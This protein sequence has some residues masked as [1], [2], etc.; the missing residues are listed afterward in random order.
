MYIRRDPTYQFYCIHT[1]QR[2]AKRGGGR[3]ALHEKNLMTARAS[4]LLK[5][6]AF[7]T[8]F[9]ACFLPGRAKDLSAPRY[10]YS[11]PT[12]GKFDLHLTF[13]KVSRVV[14]VPLHSNCVKCQLIYSVLYFVAYTEPNLCTCHLICLCE[15]DNT[16]S[17][18]YP[19]VIIIN[20]VHFVGGK[21]IYFRRRFGRN[22][23]REN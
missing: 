8:C 21:G 9:R 7:L 3:L 1:R 19:E 6:H 23:R 11:V 18:S 16:I 13:R 20:Y 12:C 15:L 2:S 4:M 22:R 14:S 5:S 10:I 17:F